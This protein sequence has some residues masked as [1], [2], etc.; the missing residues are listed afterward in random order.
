MKT[1][2]LAC[3][4]AS[5]F[6]GVN[7]TRDGGRGQRVPADTVYC[8][9]FRRDVFERFGPFDERFV[10]SQDDELNLRI[11]TAGGTVVLDPSISA[12]Y[13]PRGSWRSVLRQYHDYGYWKVAVMRKHGRATS[14]RS[15][16][17]GAF[18]GS[19]LV[20]GAAS[21]VSRKARAGLAAEVALYGS[22][23]VAA[24]AVAV[25]RCEPRPSLPA[26]ASAFAAFH[27]GYGTGML[28]GIVSAVTDA[29]STGRAT[30]RLVPARAGSSS[31]RPPV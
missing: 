13:R 29:G 25:R 28:R 11:R 18:A 30:R 14:L 2:P 9:A 24:S 5:P 1:S 3:A 4:L 21:V 26:V 22:A 20:L 23:S 10:R 6:G 31:R 8:G 12:R 19:L 16:V 27:L 15:L 17:P 7:W